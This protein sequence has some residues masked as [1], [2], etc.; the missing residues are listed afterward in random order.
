MR[1]E[2][3]KKVL[4]HPLSPYAR[5]KLAISLMY[6]VVH[7]ASKDDVVLL[8]DFFASVDA[9]Q[10]FLEDRI[11]QMKFSGH[12]VSSR[13]KAMQ[14]WV[15]EA[16]APWL[17]VPVNPID[18]PGTISDEEAQYYEYIGAL[19]EGFGEPI[20]LGP[21]LGKSTRHIIRGL[22]KNPHFANKKLHVFDDF[23]WRTS[24]MDHHTPEHLR[25]PNHA[26]FRPLFEKF[27]QDV[28]PDLTI[29]KARI[30][31]YEGNGH[32]PDRMG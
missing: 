11:R 20:G 13:R 22:R 21:W 5:K 32:L 17:N 4:Y 3:V 15:M 14:T 19:Y 23:I 10:T 25:L 12:K 8:E 27:V 1:K 26:D 24:W 7:N 18:M 16:K 30:V 31:N 28:I 6:D 2:I 29:A 9:V